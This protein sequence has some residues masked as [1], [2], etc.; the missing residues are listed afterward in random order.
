MTLQAQDNQARQRA[1][2][3]LVC[4][5]LPVWQRHLAS[6]RSQSEAAV[7]QMVAAF[8]EIVAPLTSQTASG[9]TASDMNGPVERMYQGFQYEDR[10]SQMTGLLQQDM[11]RLLLALSESDTSMDT[12]QWLARLESGYVM[13]EQHGATGAAQPPVINDEATF[14]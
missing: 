4:D 3:Q 10:I 12:R 7:N 5:V 11:Q 13:A 14:F 9:M 1:L 6:S 2:V 8:G